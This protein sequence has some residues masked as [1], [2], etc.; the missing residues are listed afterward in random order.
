MTAPYRL[1]VIDDEPADC[2]LLYEEECLGTYIAQGTLEITEVLELGEAR[3]DGSLA[4]F[5]GFLIDWQLDTRDQSGHHVLEIIRREV[6]GCDAFLWTKSENIPERFRPLI[7]T[8]GEHK[9]PLLFKPLDRSDPTK[10]RRYLREIRSDIGRRILD[11]VSE[12]EQL[13]LTLGEPRRLQRRERSV[14]IPNGIMERLCVFAG[15]A[16]LREHYV[17]APNV[18]FFRV[19]SGHGTYGTV[20]GEEDGGW[21][22]HTYEGVRFDAEDWSSISRHY[23]SRVRPN[24]AKL[25][26]RLF[27]KGLQLEEHEMPFSTDRRRHRSELAG[28]PLIVNRAGMF[29]IRTKA[30]EPVLD[31]DAMRREWLPPSSEDIVGGRL[32]QDLRGGD[33]IL[34]EVEAVLAAVGKG[35]FL[36][37]QSACLNGAWL[38]PRPADPPTIVAELYI[39]SCC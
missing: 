1:L 10:Y 13:V 25:R 34:R 37:A 32:A 4:R 26:S 20:I 33:E 29:T 23:S 6:P 28:H 35:A 39:A 15:H 17:V 31:A 9:V 14:S 19:F 3:L 5:D 12:S 2:G 21:G 36:D 27:E 8:V 7:Q 16:A 24:L 18:L 22:Y 30:N 11:R 38:G